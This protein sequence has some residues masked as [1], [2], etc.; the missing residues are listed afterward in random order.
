METK[1]IK[2]KV[3]IEASPKRTYEAILDPKIHSEF[4]QAEAEND[5]A[6]GAKF[7]AYDGYISGVNLELKKDKKIVQKWT[8]NDL[9][10]G[11][12]TTVAFEFKKHKKGTELIFTQTDIPEKSCKEIAQGWKNFYWKPLKAFFKMTAGG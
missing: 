5:M 2:Q 6:V 9:P 11:R 4:T 7:S 12:Y 8:S 3:I 10:E 1:S